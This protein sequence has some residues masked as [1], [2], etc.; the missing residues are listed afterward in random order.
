MINAAVTQG[1][2]PAS[3]EQQHSGAALSEPGAALTEHGHGAAEHTA[4]P[5]PRSSLL[6]AGTDA[7]RPGRRSPG[8]VSAIAPRAGAGGPGQRGAAVRGR[9]RARMAAERGGWRGPA[10]AL[11]MAAAAAPATGR[12]KDRRHPAANHKVAWGSFLWG[13]VVRGA[14]CSRAGRK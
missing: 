2:P 3:P 11:T 1:S 5:S 6:P 7:R 4:R 10:R 14:V 9:G 8:S 12:E 13:G